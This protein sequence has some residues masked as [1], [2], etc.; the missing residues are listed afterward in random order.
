M[1]NT[2]A[3][4]VREDRHI[5]V[6]QLAQALDISKLSIRTILHEKLKMWSRSL[7]GSS[8]PDSKTERPLYWDLLQVAKKNLEWAKCDGLHNYKWWELDSPLRFNHKTGK[9]ALDVSSIS[10]KEGSP[11]GEIDEQ[12][13]VHFVLQC[14]INSLSAYYPSIYD[15]QCAVPLQSFKNPAET[16]ELEAWSEEK[17][18]L[19]YHENIKPHTVSIFLRIFG[20]R[21]N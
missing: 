16:C 6:Q 10:S 18:W 19:L 13:Y 15:N 11:S 5:T 14:V 7:L 17:N 20:K 12:G 21:R 2:V 4:L 8:F 1:V 9:R 3:V